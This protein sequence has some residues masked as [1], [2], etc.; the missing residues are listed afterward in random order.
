MKAILYFIFPSLSS[1]D[2]IYYYI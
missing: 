1:F 2:M